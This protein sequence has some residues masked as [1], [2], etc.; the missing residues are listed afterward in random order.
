M[1][2]FGG[3]EEW[4]KYFNDIYENYNNNLFNEENIGKA[5]AF[6]NVQKIWD[7]AS[8]LCIIY[9]LMCTY[10]NVY[11]D[12]SFMLYNR[13][14]FDLLKLLIDDKKVGH[15]V[16]FGTDFYVVAQKAIEKRLYHTIKSQLGEERFHKVS[17]TNNKT[18][19]SS[20][21]LHL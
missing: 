4:Q 2:H 6:S 17:V 16:L 8:W 3:S 18:F 7:S 10:E 1:A 21:F 12:M 19:L 11:A 9:D 15:K 13:E 20:K 5:T 14:N